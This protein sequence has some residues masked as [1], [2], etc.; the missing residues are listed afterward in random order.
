MYTVEIC[1]NIEIK[2]IA[3][4]DTW[5]EAQKFAL[6]LPDGDYVVIF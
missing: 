4:F 6:S 1:T 5:A 3:S 2:L